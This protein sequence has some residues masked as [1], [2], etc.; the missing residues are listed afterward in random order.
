M[1]KLKLFNTLATWC[2]G[3]NEKT[4]ML[5]KIE[6]RRRRGWQR[7][8]WLD[9]ITDVIDLS[10][11]SLWKLM[12]DREAWCAE[13]HRVAKSQTRLSDWTILNMKMVLWYYIAWRALNN[14]SSLPSGI[15]ASSLVHLTPPCP[16]T[17]YPADVSWVMS[18]PWWEPLSDFPLHL[19]WYPDAFP[20]FWI[21]A[22][23]TLASFSILFPTL[24]PSQIVF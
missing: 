13:V 16:S 24:S 12:M 7:M 3:P 21:C 10:L 20:G 23:P 18:L 8:R 15:P 14:C 19:G 2:K 17:V 5:G 1:L 11:S 6:G 22:Y 4:L 9:G